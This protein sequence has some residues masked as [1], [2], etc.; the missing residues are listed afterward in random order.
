VLAGGPGCGKSF[1]VC[2]VVEL[3]RA[4]NAKVMLAAASA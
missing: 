3:A 1:T 4:R 2:S